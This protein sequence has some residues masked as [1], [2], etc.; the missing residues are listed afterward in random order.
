MQVSDKPA[1][2]RLQR[3]ELSRKRALTMA[4]AVKRQSRTFFSVL[5]H[6]VMLYSLSFVF[7][8]PMLY[9]ISKSLMQSS[10]LTDAAVQWIPKE[11]SFDN[12]QY[13]YI[14]LKYM[15][16]FVNSVV[17]SLV[18]A[19]IQIFSCAVIGYGF[20][21]YRFPGY[22]IMLGLVL[23]TFLVPP[24]TIIVPLYMFFSDLNWINTYFPFIVPPVLGHG[25]RG[26]LFV[27]IFLQFFRGLPHQ[28]EEAA[29]IDG[30]GAFRTF[31][32]VMLPLARS[33]M[34]VVF[35]F[36]LVWHW[37]DLFQPNLFTML[38]DKFNLMQN[39]AVM[40][41]QGEQ[42]MQQGLGTLTVN[43]VG[44]APTFANRVMAGSL[45]TILPMLLLY[46]FTQRYFVE[47][48]ERAGLAGD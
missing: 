22:S 9:L 15:G 17:T 41:G 24:Q 12:F 1:G 38:S 8:Y 43:M 30:A 36:S 18:P 33:A 40:D 13:A 39:L 37:N 23:F 32:S 47:S 28:L 26:A 14:D 19:I 5:F 35:L 21:R 10:D 34:L 31:W 46:L 11:L 7:L 42:E 20:A 44:L 45:I 2:A 29:R 27:L 4:P 16:A 25:L 48:V 6:Y 3:L